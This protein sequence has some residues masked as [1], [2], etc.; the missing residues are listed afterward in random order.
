MPLGSRGEK[1]VNIAWEVG[2]VITLH[3]PKIDAV[4]GSR[5]QGPDTHDP[6]AEVVMSSAGDI[7]L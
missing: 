2:V 3:V 6:V 4:K 7:L 5:Q 1:I